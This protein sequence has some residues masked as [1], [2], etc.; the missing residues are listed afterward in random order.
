[1]HNLFG[2]H[3]ED[4]RYHS[5]LKARI[6]AAYPDKLF[7]AAIDANTP[8]VL[9]DAD[10]INS[11]TLIKNHDHL[12]MK[13]A[14]CLRQD[15]L[16]Y[17]KN[18]PDSKWPPTIEDLSSDAR[19]PP[20]SL[21]SF[22]SYLLKNKDHPN[23]HTVNRLIQSYSSDL[24]HGVTRGKVITGEHFLLGLGLHN[25]TGQ[26]V[27]VQ[28]MNN[29]SHCI[30]YSLVCEI[31]TAQAEAAEC[32]AKSS[33]ALPIK[34]IS[35]SD[36]VLTYFWVD[37]FDM[38]L[39]TQTGHGAFNST[40]MV[41]FQEELP[42][43]M[44]EIT[45]IELP[46]SKRRS[47]QI[48]ESEPVDLIVNANKEPPLTF[49]TNIDESYFS[50]YQEF[51]YVANYLLWIIMRKLN[52]ADRT[53]STY[54]GWRTCVKKLT[55]SIPLKKTVLKYLPPI[56]AKV[57][58]FSTIYKYLEYL[59]VLASE[60]NMPYVLDV[61]AAMNAE[62]VLWNYP[63]KF[64]NVLIHLGD[65]HFVKVNFGVIGKIVKG[66][67][68]EDIILQVG[69]CSAG[70]LNGVSTG[71]HYNRAWTV[72]RAFSEAS[73]RCLFE[74]FISEYNIPIPKDFLIAAELPQSFYEDVISNNVT[75]LK[76]Y[77]EFKEVH[78]F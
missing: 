37:N 29:L 36:C 39:E 62:R 19:K 11:H 68:F 50:C 34:P 2:V 69:V 5:K 65:F 52:A 55:S 77:L 60:V 24:I 61:G 43:P 67:G 1:M 47:L 40:H 16:E 28:V 51:P 3:T 23:R 12:L 75:F 76:Q 31:E 13:A 33:G 25:M 72:H 71:F 78:L 49:C 35:S 73:E 54:S 26:K 9:I 4:T 15:I 38:N 17:A 45:D 6:Q 56:N 58:E 42:L 10:A 53:V 7:F 27:P 41:A 48:C 74:R 46:R 64:K 70:S 32:I 57:T 63:L 21:E 30:D 22:M 20:K 59:Q 18:I 66:S 14:E 44:L 8:E